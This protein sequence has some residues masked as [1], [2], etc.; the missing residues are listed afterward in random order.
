MTFTNGSGGTQLLGGDTKGR[1]R[2]PAAKRGEILGE[3]GG[4]R[5]E[6]GGRGLNE[7]DLGPDL[8]IHWSSSRDPFMRTSLL[9]ISR[10]PKSAVRTLEQP[11]QKVV[12]EAG[13]EPATLRFSVACSTN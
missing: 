12:A 6:R 5:I 7:D 13:I 2:T 1:V 10:I 3:I 8:H 9:S 4:G 11:L